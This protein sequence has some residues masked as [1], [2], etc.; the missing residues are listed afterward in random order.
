MAT[1]IKKVLVGID[2]S[3]DSLNALTWAANYAEDSGAALFVVYVLTWDQELMR[4]LPPSGFTQWRESLYRQ[5]HNE[6]TTRVRDMGIPYE[7]IMVEAENPVVGL[8]RV[9][10][11]NEVDLL[12]VGARGR[13][14][15]TDRLLGSTSYKITHRSHRPVVTVP[16]EWELKS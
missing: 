13:G 9:A 8:L 2:G 14:A 12:V 10:D 15:F 4:D 11:Q 7:C 5:L 6:W 1:M 3:E 16:S